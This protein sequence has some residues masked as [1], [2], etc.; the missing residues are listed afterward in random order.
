MPSDAFSED[1]L[2]EVHLVV[3]EVIF[4]ERNLLLT[5]LSL[6]K[7]VCLHDDVVRDANHQ[8]FENLSA[9]AR[10][11]ERDELG[12]DADY[13]DTLLREIAASVRTL[14]DL[15]DCGQDLILQLSGLLDGCDCGNFA[16]CDS[17]DQLDFVDY[18]QLV[19]QGLPRCIFHSLVRG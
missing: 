14:A 11:S 19:A 2:C 15:V 13:E 5:V 6:L 3:E 16:F 7:L 9:N 4:S 18:S 8:N 17:R 1:V 10:A 12:E